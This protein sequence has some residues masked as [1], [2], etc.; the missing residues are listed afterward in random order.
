[1]LIPKQ[2][3]R[4]YL[5]FLFLG[6]IGIAGNSVYAVSQQTASPPGSDVAT[7]QKVADEFAEV[8]NAWDAKRIATFYSEDVI[9]MIPHIPNRVGRA[10]IEQD[11]EELFAQYT[12]H[13]DV[14]IDEA[15][16]YGDMAFDRATYRTTRTPRTGG[17]TVVI[18]GRLL[19]ILRKEDGRWK[20]FRVVAITD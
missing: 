13:V 18:N 14:H 20:S 6:A 12:V 11:Y 16:I 1:M 17:E 5:I 8:F 2:P 3:F 4:S 7:L 19:E 15:K 9:Y 10:T